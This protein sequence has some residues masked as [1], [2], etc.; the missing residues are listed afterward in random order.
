[1]GW[2][3]KNPGSTL[4]LQKVADV[5][6]GREGIWLRRVQKTM[7]GE[8]GIKRQNWKRIKEGQN[9]KGTRLY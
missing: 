7:K 8:D 9:K 1:M 3:T 2:G 5:G 4:L 6:G